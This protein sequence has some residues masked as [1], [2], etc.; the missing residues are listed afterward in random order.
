MHLNPTLTQ[1][2]G[3]GGRTQGTAGQA[4]LTGELM[5]LA[6]PQAVGTLGGLPQA[7]GELWSMKSV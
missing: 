2:D 4:A 3:G 6:C 5:R 1:D 7:D